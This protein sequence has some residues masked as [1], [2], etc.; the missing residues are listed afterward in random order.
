MGSLV[1][2]QVVAVLERG[3]RVE[4]DI[5]FYIE[6]VACVVCLDALDLLDCFGESHR[7]VEHWNFVSFPEENR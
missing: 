3:A 6:L 7:Q 2:P 1:L 4:D 5:N